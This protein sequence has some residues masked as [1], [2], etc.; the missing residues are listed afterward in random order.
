MADE[1]YRVGT[2][3]AAAWLPTKFAPAVAGYWFEQLTLSQAATD[4]SS[5]VVPGAKA[6]SV[7]RVPLTTA[8]TKTS[9]TPLSYIAADT[10]LSATITLSTQKALSYLVEDIVQL[11]TSVDMFISYYKA[12]GDSLALSLDTLNATTVKG[13]TTNTP[14]ITG[15]DNTITYQN[16]LSAQTTFNGK[17]IKVRNCVMG[18]APTAFELSVIDWGDKFFSS[19]YRNP[20]RPGFWY[21]GIEGDILGMQVFVDGNWTS[22]TTDECATI[23]HPLALLYATSGV[24]IVGPVAVPLE[25]GNGF[26]VHT[27]AG[28]TVA[29]ANGVLKI[30]ND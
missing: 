13:E 15:T 1:A 4:Y 12:A 25:V 23:W 19:S 2:T 8:V 27:I 24:Q 14:I 16:L 22:G 10:H 30:V 9:G 17:R 7:P 11:Q 20:A 21:D 6:I 18:I 3:E 5:M 26:T 28:A 29:D